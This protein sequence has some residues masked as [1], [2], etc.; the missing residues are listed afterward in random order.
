ML[1]PMK[2]GRFAGRGL[3]KVF[4][5]GAIAVVFPAFEVRNAAAGPDGSA[6]HTQTEKR[7]AGLYPTRVRQVDA[8]HPDPGALSHGRPKR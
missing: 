5:C 1:A 8:A 2:D 7:L 3:R 4:G 6:T